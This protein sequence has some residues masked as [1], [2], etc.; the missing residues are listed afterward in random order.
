[1]MLVGLTLHE[2]SSAF[3]AISIDMTAFDLP[4]LAENVTF[5]K[6]FSVDDDNCFFDTER[7][8]QKHS[9]GFHT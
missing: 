1:M 9:P 7:G 4:A 8:P 2:T 3:R 5:R 6:P